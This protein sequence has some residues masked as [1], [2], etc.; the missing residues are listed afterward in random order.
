MFATPPLLKLSLANTSIQTNYYAFATDIFE[1]YLKN[2]TH[3][4]GS[5]IHTIAIVN[6]T[7]CLIA[8]NKYEKALKLLTEALPSVKLAG[9]K[10]LKAVLYSRL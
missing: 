10:E 4:T 2:N 8:L 5:K 6:Y 7:E 3:A 9:D 1:D